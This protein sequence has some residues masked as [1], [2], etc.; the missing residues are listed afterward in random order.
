M[1]AEKLK[2]PIKDSDGKEQI[3]SVQPFVLPFQ[4]DLSAEDKRLSGGLKIIGQSR[5]L[6][7]S[8]QTVDNLGNM[9]WQT[10]G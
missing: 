5:S 3:V 1:S 10:S 9:V 4:K 7:L 8:E 6:Y 2:L